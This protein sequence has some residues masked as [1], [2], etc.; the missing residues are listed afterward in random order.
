MKTLRAFLFLLV[1]P[2]LL[3]GQ[4]PA[5]GEI[6]AN[7]YTPLSQRDPVIAR[8]PDGRFVVVWHS[9]YQDG[10][11]ADL[12]ARLFTA[13]GR[14][15][16]G[17]IRISS[18]PDSFTISPVVAMMDDGSFV[19]VWRHSSAL[20]HT[21][22]S[23]TGRRFAA[24]G[25]PLGNDF[26]ISRFSTDDPGQPAVATRG[27]G[28]FVVVWGGG[29]R[30]SEIFGRWYGA[31]G[32]PLG[33]AFQVN[34]RDAADTQELP[35]VA[36][37]PAGELVVVWRSRETTLIGATAKFEVDVTNAI[38]AQRFA[39]DG[40]RLGPEFFPAPR[41]P[42]LTFRPKVLKDRAGNFFVAWSDYTTGTGRLLG[43]RFDTDGNPLGRVVDLGDVRTVTSDLAVDAHGNLVVAREREDPDRWSDVFVRRYAPD[44]TPL[45]PELRANV[46]THHLQH[47]PAVAADRFGNFVVA[48][49]SYLQDGDLSSIQARLY[50]SGDFPEAARLLLRDGRFE[51]YVTWRDGQGHAGTGQAVPMTADSGAFWFFGADNLELLVKVLDGRPV[52]GSFWVF[53]GALSDVEYTF[54][55]L[56][57]ETG[58]SKTYFNPPGRL[59]SVGDTGA[60]PAPRTAFSEAPLPVAG[61]PL[62]TCAGTGESLCLNGGRFRVAVTWQTPARGTGPGHARPLTDETG[63]FWFFGPDNLELAVKVLDGRAVNGRFWVFYASLTDVEFALTV[64]DTETGNVRTYVN[65]AGR[66]AS[67][68]DTAA[69]P[70]N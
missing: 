53:Y 31:D 29:S 14:P 43:R 12:Y 45:G 33:R 66:L 21:G 4:T 51:V 69:L 25:T 11:P 37:G 64:T 24:D 52:N 16:G 56:D 47:K 55:V 19:V 59:A 30:D 13:D 41:L 49:D 7:V 17:E 3:A 6:Q 50:A 23:I 26:H 5:S 65:P 42:R 68:A 70:G 35:S 18:T 20:V 9:E 40:R 62:A 48:W 58:L 28:S 63:A 44:G 39:A 32:A 22:Y 38:A 57:T 46:T 54:T 67:L 10:D 60:L 15:R 36:V 1:L 8:A 2:A 27:D 61:Q 34:R